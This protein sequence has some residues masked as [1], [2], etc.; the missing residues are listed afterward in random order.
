[1]LPLGWD[2][3]Q[4]MSL[5]AQAFEIQPEFLAPMAAANSTPPGSLDLNQPG[6]SKEI[7]GTKLEVKYL[8]SE[9]K[10]I[11]RRPFQAQCGHRYCS[12]CLKKIISSG[13]QKCASCIQE[14][15]YEEGVSIL[16]T[17]SA[18]PDNAARREVESLPAI[19]INDGCTWK[20][21]IKEY[22]SCH[23]GNCPFMLIECQACKGMIKLNEK[24]RHSEREC[25]ER[26]LN[27][28]Y[29]KSLFYFPDIKAHDEVCPKF[30]LTC[31]GCG[32]KKI[33]REKFQDHV[34]TCGKCKVPCR[35][36]VVGCAEMVENEKLPEH[37]SKCLVE[38]LYMLL[39][40]VLS[41]K[42]GSGG[43]KHHAAF[44][45]S[46]S[47]SPLLAA[48]ALCSESDLSKSLELLGRCEALERKTV[49]FENI[50][51]V[52]NRE[53]ERVSLTAEAYSR[54]HRLDQEKIETLSNKVR[55]L[56]RSIGL[57]DLAMAEMEE[58]I[59]NLEASTY[60]GVFIWKITEFARKRQEA[61]T[62]RSPAIFS[63]AFY[64]SKYGYKMCLRVYLNGDGTGRGT[65][66]SLFFVVMKGPNDALL[67]WPFNQK[68]TL[69]LLDQNNREHIIDAFRPDVTSSSFQRPITEMN[70]ASG[71]PLF[72]PVSMM[73]AKN[74][75]VRD[76]AIF[77]KAI[78]DLTGL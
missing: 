53:V 68:V 33:P 7:L 71:C 65:H 58:K 24:E 77:I 67:R 4:T 2:E 6:F 16:E 30:P 10:N 8:C 11:L 63:P 50:V 27:C 78:V 37:E 45:S 3:Q 20:G 48:N 40:F 36:Q 57:K 26:N 42:T 31:E 73:E 69:M 15:I 60:D 41:L 29:C 59:R 17:S 43:L 62:G 23:E 1:M 52:L 70:I 5:C 14:G 9:C 64:T 61:I 44:S 32:K 12:Y 55:Q 46:Q 49:T 72:C 47:N 39:S 76:D 22:E 66:L 56:E 13:P 18:F 19:C 51:C 75:Y 21:T 35:F 28:K 54:Q 38:H 25:P 74:S 34:K